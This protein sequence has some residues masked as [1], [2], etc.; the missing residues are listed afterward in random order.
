MHPRITTHSNAFPKTDPLASDL[1][2][3]RRL[4]IDRHSLHRAKLETEG[5]AAARALVGDSGVE[6][7]H[8][9]H[10]NMF[11][12]ADPGAWPAE[13]QALI[14]SID[15]AAELGVPVLYGTTG[16]AGGLTWE[17][18]VEHL[19]RALIVPR[20]HARERGVRLL[21]ETTNPQY[22]DID[23]FH[24]LRDT[25]IGAEAVGA[26]VCLDIHASWTEAGLDGTIARAAPLIGLVQVSDYAPGSRTLDRAVPGEGVIPLDRIIGWILATGYSGLFDIELVNGAGATDRDEALARAVTNLTAILERLGA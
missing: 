2:R 24:S 1:A 5:H 14:D 4:G 17:A 6:I 9:V 7:T 20:A 15:T 13:G 23:C 12:L 3:L 8:L 22:A 21:F 11:T 25:V 19:G 10:S 26:G 18:A 16:P